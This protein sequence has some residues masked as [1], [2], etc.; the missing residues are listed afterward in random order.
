MLHERD[1]AIGV[2][3]ILQ[4][5]LGAGRVVGQFHEF[6]D[7]HR[8]GVGNVLHGHV[9]RS[10]GAIDLIIKGSRAR[11][12]EERGIGGI[13]ERDELGERSIDADA[14]DVV[15]ATEGEARRGVTAKLEV[16][17]AARTTEAGRSPEAIDERV[18]RD[19]ARG[20]IE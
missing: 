14:A 17:Q 20:V 15:A 3:N 16:L 19:Q 18:G 11:L 6:R 2:E 8:D 5:G 4:D 7:A 12:I 13:R 1:V 10:Q 9:G